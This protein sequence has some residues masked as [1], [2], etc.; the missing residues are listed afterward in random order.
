[1][2]GADDA[3]VGSCIVSNVGLNCVEPDSDVVKVV[4]SS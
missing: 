1:M 3:G 2:R 4:K